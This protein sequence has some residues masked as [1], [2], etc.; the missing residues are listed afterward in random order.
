MSLHIAAEHLKSQGRG[1]DDQLVHMSSNEVRGLA[2]LAKAHGGQ[3]STNPK[4]GLPEAGFL[5][6]ILPTVIGVGA[7]ILTGGALTPLEI[8]LGVGGVT[9]LA[10]GNLGQG[11][12]AGLGAYGGAGLSGSLGSMGAGASMEEA[13]KQALQQQQDIASKS[14]AG[15][16]GVDQA[17]AAKQVIT[18]MTNLPPD[19]SAQLQT[20]IDQGGDVNQMGVHRLQCFGA[21]PQ[22]VHHAGGVVLQQY[23]ATRGKFSRQCNPFG[24][25]QIEHDAFFRLPQHCVQF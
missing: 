10:T 22:S 1:P 13:S 25:F 9:A 24:L 4:T 11:L 5:D 6:S 12:M 8:G 19:V 16:A 3:L 18:G 14:I 15:G 20:A 23:V 7:D 17:A 21:Q 2:A